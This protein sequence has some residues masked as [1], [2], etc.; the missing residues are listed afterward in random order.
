MP[1]DV[2]NR[3]PRQVLEAII[4]EPLEDSLHYSWAELPL[5]VMHQW[6]IRE[7]YMGQLELL[8]TLFGLNLLPHIVHSRQLIIF[9]DNDS[10]ASNLVRGYSKISDSSAIV[11]EFWLTAAKINAD[12]YCDRVSSKSR[13]AD[14]PS[15]LESKLLETLGAVWVEPVFDRQ[16]SPS[17]SPCLWFGAA[18]KQSGG[19]KLTASP[20][21]V[22]SES[23]R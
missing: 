1:P 4:Y 23:A 17:V 20:N 21:N 18:I 8:A 6:D 10:A 5:C 7:S 12:I 3:T 9:I 15:R 11:G 19:G 14:P 16:G 22:G 2:P 13:L